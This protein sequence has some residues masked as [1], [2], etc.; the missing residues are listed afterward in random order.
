MEVALVGGGD[1]R[2]PRRPADDGEDRVDDRHAED[3]ERDEQRGEEEVGLPGER[4]VRIGPAADH[5][6]RRRH[7]QPEQQRAGVAHEDPRRVEV[8]G[9]EAEADAEHDDGHERAD[10]GLR[11]Q[12]ELVEP[13][14]VE[15]ERA[16]R[17]GDDA[18]GEAVEP[19]D[20]VDGVG[21]AR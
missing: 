11:Q 7:Q 21:H 4:L 19:V 9:Q 6:G 12:A 5:G 13:L 10:V 16:R 1:A 2:A 15:E 8:V 17:D 20:E 18:G 14:A 3:D